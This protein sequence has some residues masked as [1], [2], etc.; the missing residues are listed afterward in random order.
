VKRAQPSRQERA[1]YWNAAQPILATKILIALNLVVYLWVIAGRDVIT[2]AGIIN[3][4][5]F[6]L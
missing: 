1:R 6:D 3:G 2:G 4:R 5:E